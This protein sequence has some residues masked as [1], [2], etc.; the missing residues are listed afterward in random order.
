MKAI[1]FLAGLFLFVLLSCYVWPQTP[2]GRISGRVTDQTGAVVPNAAVT[3]L[4]TE[5]GTKRVLTT[6]SAGEYFAPNLN[7]GLYAITVE[8]ASFKRMQRPP[9]R[10]E[11]ATD[12]QIGRAHV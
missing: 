11:V 4:N 12:V 9:F 6:N 1:K 2:Q 8:A 5:T 10:L 7:P 3:I